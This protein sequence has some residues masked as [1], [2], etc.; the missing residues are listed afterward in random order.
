MTDYKWHLNASSYTNNMYVHLP[1]KQKREI[2]QTK[3]HTDRDRQTDSLLH[4]TSNDTAILAQYS[5]LNYKAT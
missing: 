4:K 1:L 3:K 2:N 5:I